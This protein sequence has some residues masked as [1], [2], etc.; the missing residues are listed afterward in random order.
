MIKKKLIWAWSLFD[1]GNSAHSAVIATF[2]FSVYFARAV[3]GD[4]TQGSA[5]WAHMTGIAA[6]GTALI[7]PFI[8]ALADQTGRH[9]TA[10]FIVTAIT[11]TFTALLYYSYPDVSSVWYC[12]IIAGLSFVF[13]EL[14]VVINNAMLLRVTD[15]DSLGR[16]SGLG[17]GLGYIGGLICLILCL[18]LFVGLG[19]FNP[20]VTLDEETSQNIR[21]TA[22]FAALWFAIFALPLFFIFPTTAKKDATPLKKAAP[23]AWKQVKSTLKNLISLDDKNLIYFLIAS[24]LYRDGLVTL[25]A[26]GGLYAAG[27]FQMDFTEIL[28]F[29]VGLN[30][31]AG[32][33]AF[34]FG[35]LHDKIGTKATIIISLIGL[36]AVG[37]AT[38]AI[39]SKTTF[40]V[41]ALLLG[42]FMGPCQSASR[43]FIGEIAPK[44]Q[45]N[46]YYGYYALTG[47]SIAFTGPI[48][49]GLL[50][51]ISNSQRVGMLSVI[52][53]LG[54]GLTLLLKVKNNYKNVA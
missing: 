44:D 35:F 19:D 54:L 17:W 39:D 22:P 16:V 12:L 33:G 14:S 13:I 27:T 50:T 32:I 24:A 15:H 7:A 10:L 34:A 31:M 49:F 3:Y 36:I 21:V 38:L 11:I 5:L 40:L 18:V 48:L 53:L 43:V 4:E 41:L 46:E 28:I 52:I 1:F 6:L 26:V 9:K 29:A 45:M 2:I 47:K 20:L 8:G 37:S 42:V 51:S 25:F 23:K 30:F